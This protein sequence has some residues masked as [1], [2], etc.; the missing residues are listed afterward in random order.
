MIS[1]GDAVHYGGSAAWVTGTSGS[2]NLSELV[3]GPCVMRSIRIGCAPI[4]T[5]LQMVPFGNEGARTLG[6]VGSI[7]FG[8]IVNKM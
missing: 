2:F 8:T 7:A 6:Q 4:D 3:H 5:N 1:M